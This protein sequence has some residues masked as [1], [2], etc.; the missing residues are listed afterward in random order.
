MP[1]K[2]NDTMIES[3]AVHIATGGYAK[4]WAETNEVSY[5]TVCRWLELPQVKERVK[6]RRNEITQHVLGRHY[7]LASKA[8]IKLTGLLEE[9]NVHAR[10]RAVEF[11]LTNLIPMAN[12]AEV[13][14]RLSALEAANV[15]PGVDAPQA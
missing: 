2:L 1:S 14:R 12:F 7:R 5:R 13:D 4:R 3:L 15:Q 9:P 8:M 10:L 11:V 6:A